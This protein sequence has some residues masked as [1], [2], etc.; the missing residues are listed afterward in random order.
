M[1]KYVLGVY[2]KALPNSLTI[3]QK[4]EEAK[5]IGYDYLELSVDE[6]P[7]KL[8]RLDWTKEQIDEVVIAMRKT[9][10][11]IRSMALS[12]QR[13]YPMGSEDENIR[14]KSMEIIEKAIKLADNLGIRIIQLAGYDVYYEK[15][16][17]K[18]KEY[19]LKNLASAVEIASK[20]GVMLAFETMETP[21]MDTVEKARKVV[22]YINSPFLKIYPDL[23]NIKNSSLI[24]GKNV[25]DDIKMGENLTVAAH[26]KES[27]PG[28]YREIPFLQGHVNFKE[29]LRQMWSIGVRRFVTELWYVGA[30]DFRVD[31]N[32]AV[33]TFRTMLDEIEKENEC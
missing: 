26:I 10:L 2:E 7:E 20:Y 13:K 23:G 9:G 28:H 4:L 15:G 17:E 32:F 25:L 5:K 33:K 18:T 3:E 29:C 22:E 30:E 21:F 8:Q 11:N 1:K 31:L 27:L 24:Y 12:G 6:T 19:F 14:R 16:N